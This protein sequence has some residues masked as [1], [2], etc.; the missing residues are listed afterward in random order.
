MQRYVIGIVFLIICI[1]TT[2]YFVAADELED[3]NKQLHEL[4]TSLESSKNATNTNEKELIKL[5][6]QLTVI[7]S[8]VVIIEK[9]IDKKT[10]EIEDGEKR[11]LKQKQLLDERVVSYYKNKGREKDALLEMFISENINQ[12]FQQFAYQQSLLE[13]DRKAIVRIALLVRD[14]EKK[15]E[16]LERQRAQLLPIKEQIDKQSA[17]LAGEINTAK[18]YQETLKSKI[19]SLSARQQEIIAQKQASLNLP[20]SA[21]SGA[22]GCTDDR[23]IDPGFSPRFAFF[24]YGVPNRVGLNQYGAKGRAEAGQGVED[25]LRAYFD[26]FE[27][28]KDYSTGIIIKVEGHGDFNIEEYTKRIYEMPESWPLEAL[29][30]QAIAARSYALAYTNNG[31]NSICTTENCQVFKPEPKGGNWDRAVEETKGWVMM[32]GG[33]PVKAYYSSTHGGYVYATSEI[34]WNATSWTKHAQ[35]ATSGI[36]NFSDLNNNAYDKSS[37]WFYCDWG[38]RSE[39]N[40]TAWLKSEEVADIANVVL[41]AKH[42]DSSDKEH[43]Y[44]IDKSNPA[45]KETWDREKVKSEL[46]SRGGNPFSSVSDISVSADFGYGK[47]TSVNVSGDAG[48]QSFSASEFKDWFNLRAPANIQIVG[49]LFNSEKR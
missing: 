46:R 2:S 40:K 13:G 33:N 48:S 26:N 28:K 45:G 32:Q 34:G 25:I 21:G 10:T 9:D 19:A 11:L 41:L 6:E 39:Y 8:Q 43:L 4:Q 18:K 23:N 30:A 22:R 14:I 5:N 7:K 38:S 1:I 29:K 36:S 17:F 47:T 27:M 20:K 31:A 12:F 37:P 35:D 16:T 49:Q 3:I 15:K 24:T 42:L 44:Q